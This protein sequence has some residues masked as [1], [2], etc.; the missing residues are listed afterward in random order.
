MKGLS[1]VWI[2]ALIMQI[3]NLLSPSM[4][5]S[6][7]VPVRIDLETYMKD[8]DFSAVHPKGCGSSNECTTLHLIYWITNQLIN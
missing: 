2:P 5:L 4:S 1:I 8:R 6:F 3:Q 7:G